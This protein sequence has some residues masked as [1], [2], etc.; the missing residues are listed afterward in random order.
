[1]KQKRHLLATRLLLSLF[2]ALTATTAWAET[3]TLSNADGTKYVNMPKTGTNT[4]TLS[5]ATV[6]TFKVYDDGGSTGNYSSNCSGYLTLTAPEDYVLQLSGN[7]RTEKNHDNLTVYDGSTDSASK[8]LDE[9]SSTADNTLTAITTVTSSGQSMTLYFKSDGSYQKAGLDL[10]ITLIDASTKY[11][12]TVNTATG[13]SVAS[14][15]SS[16]KVNETVTLTATPSEGYILNGLSVTDANG[17]AVAV[18]WSI[19]ANTATFTMPALAVTVTPTFTNTLTAD[20]G[21]YI[22][23]PTTG[24]KTA[25]V[26]VGVQSFKVY[27]DGGSTD[28]YSNN[29]DGYLT[30]TAPG[31]LLK[32]SGYITAETDDKLTVYDGSD[33]S[34]TKLLGAVSSTS[35]DDKTDITTVTSSGQSMTLYFH[36][37]NATNYAG[38]D[39]TVTLAPDP[40]HF[41]QSGDVYTIHTAAGWGVFCDLL[42]DNDKG[43]F[44][45]KTVKLGANITVSRMAGGSNH[46]FTGT[47][48]G[49][50]NTLT[51]NYGTADS[52]IDAQYVAP[53]PTPLT[54]ATATPPSATSPSTAISMNPTRAPRHIMSADSS[55][56]STAPSLS[57]TAPATSPSPPPA[58][59][60][61]SWASAR[62]PSASPTA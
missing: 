2:A 25:T 43:Y 36:S 30:L 13:G 45:G 53:S 14:D 42:A 27:D 16:S 21:L 15:K 34:A 17:D 51:L 57:S 46:D 54:T 38:L 31:Y 39:L 60:A 23:M 1:M 24:T 61:A 32:L 40:A 18:N 8:L 52:P 20:D 33:N 41:S 37:D 56:T 6:T 62:L 19:W 22:N 44:D 10:T 4:L 9:V 59:R 35:N 48:D 47:F 49:Q 58:A 50:G 26:P 55:A 7:I 5:D 29:C 11:D 12:I 28:R 3:V